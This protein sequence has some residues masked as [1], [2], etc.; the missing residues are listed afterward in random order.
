VVWAGN[1]NGAETASVPL[2]SVGGTSL[3]LNGF[4]LGIWAGGRGVPE[5]VN[6]FEIGN[7]VALDS[8][9]ISENNNRHW[10]FKIGRTATSGFVI[11]WT[12]PWWVAIDNIDVSISAVPEPA[13]SGLTLLGALGLAAATR[14]RRA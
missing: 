6:V 3:T 11:A 10:S 4:D 5:S 12:S 1:H 8:F 7:P 14:R 9:S 13:T 2:A